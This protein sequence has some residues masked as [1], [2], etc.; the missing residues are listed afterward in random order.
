MDNKWHRAAGGW[1]GQDSEPGTVTLFWNWDLLDWTFG[2][3]LEDDPSW[4]DVHFHFGP[5]SFDICYWRKHP[6]DMFTAEADA[7]HSSG[8]N[9][10]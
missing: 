1:F 2:L 6:L 10:S 7:A 9:Q 5:I 4:R 3:R 8:M